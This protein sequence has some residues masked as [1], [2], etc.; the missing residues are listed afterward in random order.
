MGKPFGGM[1]LLCLGGYYFWI[2]KFL[3]CCF[4]NVYFHPQSHYLLDNSTTHEVFFCLFL[5]VFVFVFVFKSKSAL[6]F[7]F[8]VCSQRKTSVS[9]SFTDI[10]VWR[11]HSW[12]FLGFEI[13][14][15]V[16]LNFEYSYRNIWVFNVSIILR[17]M[18]Y[19]ETNQRKNFT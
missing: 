13:H 5:F 4:T 18:K 17:K 6:V 19:N 1:G 2:L 16:T 14:I 11:C 9:W 10:W 3:I 7:P 12:I 8:G 15:S